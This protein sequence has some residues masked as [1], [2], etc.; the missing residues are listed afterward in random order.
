MLETVGVAV[1]ANVKGL[2]GYASVVQFKVM[3]M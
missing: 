2:K 1:N 3:F